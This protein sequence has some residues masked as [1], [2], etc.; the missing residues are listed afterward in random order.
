MDYKS[1]F[2]PCLLIAQLWATPA[3]AAIILSVAPSAS[4]FNIGDS[5]FIDVM[6]H[7]D[8]ADALDSYLIG[9]NLTGGPGVVFS[10][11]QSE[12]FLSDGNYVFF[13]RSSSVINGF[14]ATT[15]GGGGSNVTV[16][17]LT[18]DPMSPPNPLP[19]VLPGASSPSLLTRLEFDVVGAGSFSVHIDPSS[20]FSDVDF[21][22][23]S[24][25]STGGSFTAVPE[26]ASVVFLGIGTVGVGLL[27]RRRRLKN[28][29][30]E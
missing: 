20:T 30:S 8:S 1:V 24:F 6:I 16:G 13:G 14:P 5:G 28:A 7:S 17:D 25:S 21:N 2:L 19:F 29:S 18:E 23:F 9:L 11:P 10:S 4:T 27:R 15:V 3:E 22:D 12:A 26:P